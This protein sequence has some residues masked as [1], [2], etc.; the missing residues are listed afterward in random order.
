MRKLLQKDAPF[1]WTED[2]QNELE[3]LKQCLVSDPVLQPVNINEDLVI[4]SDA[5]ER[6]YSFIALQR[7]TDGYLH[8]IAYG[9]RSLSK[10][11]KNYLPSELELIAVTLGLKYFE[12]WAIHKKVTVITDNSSVL[13]LDRWK[14][15]NARQRR[16][17]AYLMQYNLCVKYIPGA[18][19]LAADALS[20]CF[21]D[22]EP[23]RKLQ[24][25][26]PPQTK[27]EF[28]VSITHRRP[29]ES[30][31]PS[32]LVHSHKPHAAEKITRSTE[33]RHEYCT[34][35]DVY[36]VIASASEE[37]CFA[38]NESE[39]PTDADEIINPEDNAPDDAS[40]QAT[41][42]SVHTS[43]THHSVDGTQADG[44]N[45]TSSP[46]EDSPPDTR[47]NNDS[48]CDASDD[49]NLLQ[50]PAITSQDYCV[51]AEFSNIYNYLAAGHL[52]GTDDIDRITLLVAEQYIIEDHR[53]YKL[54]LPRN[55][56][57]KKIRP[58]TQR[59]C[60]PKAFRHDILLH[61]HNIGHFGREKMYQT[62]YPRIFWKQMFQDIYDFVR[63]CDICLK[64][65]RNFAFRHVPLNPLTVPTAPF[66]I[67]Q[68]DHKT[69][70]RPTKSGKVAI[71][72]MVDSF[73]GWA[74]LEPVEN[75]TAF[76]TAKV[77]IRRIISCF[78]VPKLILTDRGVSFTGVFFKHIANILG[79]H[80]RFSATGAKR[81]NGL[82][83]A[84]V[85]RTA[86][87]IKI[88]CTDDKQIDQALPL[89]ELALNSSCH[90]T[91]QLSA[92]EILFGRP[93][94]LAI[95][96]EIENV[97]SFST[98]QRDYYLWLA[99]ELKKLHTA[100]RENKIDI[101][102]QDKHQYDKRYAVR[103][104]KWDIGQ[105][106]LVRNDR[107][108]PKS[109][110]VLSHK[111]YFGPLFITDIV[112]GQQDIGP[113]YKLVDCESGRRLRGLITADRLKAY[114]LERSELDARLPRLKQ[115]QSVANQRL[116][117]QSDDTDTTDSNAHNQAAEASNTYYP[118]IRILKER[119]RNKQRQYYVLFS[120]HSRE[121]CFDITPAL[122]Q[123][124]RI[125]QDRR[126]TRRRT[127][128]LRRRIA[129]TSAPSQSV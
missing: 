42:P 126:R 24:F 105:K 93:M 125:L 38:A 124:Y 96:G 26:A 49:G 83:E 65:K 84:V 77:F 14:P 48:E 64:A 85:K 80:H 29:D 68:L 114:T 45:E 86:E 58:C 122:L 53:L 25:A 76:L 60:I 66:E 70:P 109:D 104:P 31:N 43:Q 18:K 9:G 102:K 98:D 32:E 19:N 67:V 120:D 73:S 54:S 87:L 1:V 16:L 110:I 41:A 44:N 50:L 69:L 2:C 62:M 106:V 107:I 17:I 40:T 61:F 121:W 91:L 59:L 7:G 55:S 63:S 51:D 78:G 57:E 112:Q 22:M 100:V 47:C 52:T 118:A 127:N 30:L 46:S 10:S 39:S 88:Y 79:I 108:K 90:T 99:D 72:C 81:T 89:M 111:P 92:H 71:L 4:M 21:D 117:P 129:R 5:C 27:E 101:K 103:S 113:S 123:H 94:R 3:Y 6:G 97:P 37:D 128:A 20:R 119:V 36:S 34:L 23:D 13:H 75:L 95:P 33:A 8:S 35:P 74:V 11:Q 116:Q 82:S 15:V 115:T 28:I 12:Y 56:R